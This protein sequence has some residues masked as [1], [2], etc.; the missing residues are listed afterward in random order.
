MSNYSSVPL[1]DEESVQLSNV[2]SSSATY[3]VS[4]KPQS[5]SVG[6]DNPVPI[7]RPPSKGRDKPFIILFFLHFVFIGLFSLLEKEENTNPLLRRSK[8]GNW[9]SMVMISTILGSFFGSLVIFLITNS[10]SRSLFLSQSIPI[11]I[12]IQIC[13]ANIFFL[14]GQKLF[15]LGT[16]FLIS[17]VYFSFRYK[18]CKD[19][20]SFTDAVICFVGE[21]SLRYGMWLTL[22]CA[23]IVFVHT[24]VLLGWGVFMVNLLANISTKYVSLLLIGMFFSLYWVTKL[25]HGII[26]HIVGACIVWHFVRDDKDVFEPRKRVLLHLQCAFSTSLGSLW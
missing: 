2:D 13:L 24:C 17:A 6:N 3:L 12:I 14:F 19:S 10:E 20:L 1:D 5:S 9:T 22:I 11:S 8:V 16:V 21:I 18:R 7:T 4:S 23:L 26:A 15:L 25:F